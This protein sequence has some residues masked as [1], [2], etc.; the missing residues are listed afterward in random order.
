MVFIRESEHPVEKDWHALAPPVSDCTINMLG[1]D[2]WI[3]CHMDGCLSQSLGHRC[4]SLG[5]ACL[6][7]MCLLLLPLV[8]LCWPAISDSNLISPTSVMGYFFHYFRDLIYRV[9]SITWTKGFFMTWR[10]SYFWRLTWFWL[11]ILVISKAWGLNT[12]EWHYINTL[13]IF[14]KYMKYCIFSHLSSILQHLKRILCTVCLFSHILVIPNTEKKW[15]RHPKYHY[16]NL[17]PL[18]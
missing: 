4:H 15:G 1:P 7:F 5:K 6:S 2:L 18:I 14:P 11:F 8:I 12:S 9:N 17:I 13:V 3:S 16:I 10:T